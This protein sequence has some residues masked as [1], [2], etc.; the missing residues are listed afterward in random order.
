[1]DLSRRHV[2]VGTSALIG[3]TV[4]AGTQLA[5]SIERQSGDPGATTY[6]WDVVRAVG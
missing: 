5:R 3:T 4:A 1:M 6:A 2:M